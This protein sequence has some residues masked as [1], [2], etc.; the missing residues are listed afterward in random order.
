MK[1]VKFFRKT[2]VCLVPITKE[3]REARLG[4]WMKMA[5][6]RHRFQRKIRSCAELIECCLKHVHREKTSRV[7][8]IEK[9]NST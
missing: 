1:K 9:Y 4:P 3:D 2:T 7:L 8:Y 5:R 6:D